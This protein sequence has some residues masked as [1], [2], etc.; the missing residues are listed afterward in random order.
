MLEQY[1]PSLFFL[2]KFLGL[3]FVLNILY[4]FYFESFSPIADPITYFVVDN[5]ISFLGLFYNGLDFEY[6]PSDQLVWMALD[7]DIIL[8]AYEG[9]NGVNVMILF[10]SFIIAYKGELKSTV[11][12]ILMGILIIHL[13]NI[14]R[15]AILFVVAERYQAYLYFTHKYLF[16]G[17]IYSAVF[18]LW[19]LWVRKVNK[20]KVQKG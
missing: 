3:Y 1:K 5:T 14:L 16:T 2:A 6:Y 12:F 19:F 13:S 15:I 8:N 11:W 20:Q 4:G 18:F 17:I 10:L 7:K 9:C